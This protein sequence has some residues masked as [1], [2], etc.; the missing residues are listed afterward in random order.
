MF[1]SSIVMR[2]LDG[3]F[4]LAFLFLRVGGLILAS[5]TFVHGISTLLDI[6][7]F[8]HRRACGSFSLIV[9]HFRVVDRRVSWSLLPAPMCAYLCL[10]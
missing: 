10:A 2:E 8:W 9:V 4:H 1:I 3:L 6:F 5:F 7:V